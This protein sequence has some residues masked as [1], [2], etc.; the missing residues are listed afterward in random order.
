MT[1]D[2]DAIEHFLFQ[3]YAPFGGVIEL[4]WSLPG[5]DAISHA[6]HYPHNKPDEFV[7]H[8]ATLNAGGHN[9]YFTPAIL[10]ADVTGRAHDDDVTEVR[11]LWTDL[12]STEAMRARSLFP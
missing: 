8:A 3:M 4:A 5:Q 2:K 10:G 11:C 1:P 6:E 9:I 7:G 12:D